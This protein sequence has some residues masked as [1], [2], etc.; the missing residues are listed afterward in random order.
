MMV[1]PVMDIKGGLVVQAKLGMRELYKPITESV[2]GTC[3]PFE[4]ALKFSSEGFR[5]IYIADL[6]SILGCGV[7][8]KVFNHLR[9][10][11]FKIIADIGV[12]N[13]VKL[14]EAM[15]LADY[16]VIATEAI[17][18]LDFLRYALRKCG[19]RAFLSLDTRGKTVISAAMEI[20]GLSIE[21]MSEVLRDIGVQRVL[22]IDFDRIGA[23][24]GPD[25]DSAKLLV[26]CGFDVY[27][28]GGIRGLED[29]IALEKMGVSGALISSTLHSGNIKV[30]D[31]KR[32]GFI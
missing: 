8:E 17:P 25:F 14:E 29:I 26:Q 6:D 5:T 23:Y 31:L 13:N 20:A 2:Y 9:R 4:L 19:D 7:N 16:P 28:G 30:E 24:S 21:K 32:L 18:S 15:R 22:L 3:N 27:I 12:N 1:I 11:K 10:L